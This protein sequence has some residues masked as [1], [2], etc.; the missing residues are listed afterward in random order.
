[1]SVD[2]QESNQSINHYTRPIT[3]TVDV[4]A[5]MVNFVFG[6]VCQPKINEYDDDDQSVNHVYFRQST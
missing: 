4:S 3:I 5:V 2:Y 6:C 1:M